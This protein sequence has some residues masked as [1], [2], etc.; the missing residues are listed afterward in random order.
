MDFIAAGEAAIAK[1]EE[2]SLE[3]SGL[4]AANFPP[5]TLEQVGAEFEAQASSAEPNA[6]VAKLSLLVREQ[7]A[8]SVDDFKSAEMWIALKAPAVSDGNNFGVDVQNYVAGELKTMR[9]AIMAFVD[10]A[11][12]YHW[13]RGLGIE[14]YIEGNENESSE[15][16]TTETEGDKTTV[17]SSKSSKTSNKKTPKAMDYQRHVNCLDVKQYFSAYTMLV[18]MRNCYAKA[19][20]LFAKNQ[21]RLADPRGDG[22]EGPDRGVM[23]MF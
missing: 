20:A 19:H 22:G 10:S 6:S 18:D 23:S 9:L 16:Q 21:K 17:K 5:K 12:N 4:I 2:R 13:Q 11:G 15:S 3:L 1:L 8:I 14:K 7:A